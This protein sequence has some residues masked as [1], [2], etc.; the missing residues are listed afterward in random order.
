M[1]LSY[2]DKGN[3]EIH[4]ISMELSRFE[5][6]FWVLKLNFCLEI[7]EKLIYFHPKEIYHKIHPI[8]VAKILIYS[9][10]AKFRSF[11]DQ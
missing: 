5:V 9:D 6:L 4:A 1:L 3:R 11:C 10:F 2:A 7:T 8:L